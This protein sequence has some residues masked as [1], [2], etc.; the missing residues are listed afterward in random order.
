MNLPHDNCIGSIFSRTVQIKGPEKVADPTMFL[1]DTLVAVEYFLTWQEI[2][3]DEALGP[4]MIY[5][6]DS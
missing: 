4:L 6:C 1:L 5:A 3:T 2:T